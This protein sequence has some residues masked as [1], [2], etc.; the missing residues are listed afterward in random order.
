MWPGAGLAGE[1]ADD[2]EG[3]GNYLGVLLDDLDPVELNDRQIGERRRGDGG[4]ILSCVTSKT[5]DRGSIGAAI[6]GGGGSICTDGIVIAV[7]VST[8]SVTTTGALAFF[9]A[10]AGRSR[11]SP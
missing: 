2:L 9:A 4:S 5:G 6:G 8:V 7:A 1:L 10:V 3:L 11:S